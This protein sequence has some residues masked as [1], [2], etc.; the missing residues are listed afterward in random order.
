MTPR[1]TTS[2]VTTLA[3]RAALGAAALAPLAACNDMLTERPRSA[4]VTETYFT[5]AS[6]AKAAIAAAY[7]PLSTGSLWGTNLQWITAA[8]SDESRVGP[9]EENANIVSLT[10][11]RWTST[12]PYTSGTWSGLYQMITRA[13]LVLAKVPAITMD[14][15]QKNQIVAEAKFLRALGYHYLVRLYGDVP[16]VTT[17][18]EQLASTS[19]ARDAADKVYA[20]IVKDATE[21]EAVLPV[22]WPSTDKGRAPKAAAQAL[23]AE[24]YIWRKDWAN[25]AANT[26]KIITAGTY[27]LT[28]NYLDAFLPGSQNR[29][30]EIFAAQSSSANGAPVIDIAQWT[31]PRNMNPNAAGG[32]GTYQPLTWFIDSYPAGDYRRDVT[33]FTRGRLSTG[34][35][36]TFLP[37]INKFRPTQKPGLNQDVNYPIFR[38]AD[39]LLMHAEAL[40]EQ[41]QTAQALGFVNQV[42]ARARNGAGTEN[43][44]APADLAGLN[45]SQAREAIFQERQWELA[46]E[47]KRWFDMVRRGFDYFRAALQKDATATD[48]QQTDMLLPLPQAQLDLNPALTQNP[49]Y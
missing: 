29:S 32:W 24:H 31:Y 3:V 40:N 45:Q 36:T 38:Y 35:D 2:R 4:I 30:E 42:R 14:E 5:N 7:R 8:A 48:I 22:S 13:N 47:G 33:F 41:G 28:R 17:T 49:G 43:R 16:L 15:T 37:H 6:D 1:I 26:Q 27:S 10:Q 21:A 25:A 11:L 23:L 9:E 20:Q 18:D 46:F 39:V 34:Q 19:G 44:S 12:N